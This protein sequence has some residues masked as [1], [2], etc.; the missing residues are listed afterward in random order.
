MVTGPDPP[1][2]G[3]VS[4]PQF[5]S[6]TVSP[7]RKFLKIAHVNAQSLPCHIDEFRS[8]FDSSSFDIILICETW[9]KP[10][11]SNKSVELNDY[12]LF[13]NDR[14]HKGGGGVGVFVKSHLKTNVLHCSD[15]TIPDR[16][17]FIF[18]DVCVNETHVL[19]SVC[20][21]APNLGFMAE[22][23]L[24]LLDL[25]ARYSHVIVMGDFNTDL[26]GPP[27]YDNTFLNNMFQSFNLS[28]LP[29]RA[30]HHTSTSETWLDLMAVSD[31]DLVAH[32]GQVPAPGLSRHDLLFCVYKLRAQKSK[33]KFIQYRNLKDV[34]HDSILS[35]AMRLPW[36]DI[37]L[38]NDVDLMVGQF[39]FL[40]NS[41]LEHVA[42]MITKRVTK[43]PVPWFTD[44]IRLLQK[45]RDIS[46][47][48]AKQSKSPV[49]WSV[50]KRLRNKTQQ[51]IRNAKIRYYYQS[52]NNNC[53]STKLLWAK[54]KELGIGKSV[55]TGQ[56]NFD[57]NSINDF[58]VNI[59]VDSS[60]AQNFADEL[61][62]ARIDR[63]LNQFSFASVSEHDV[64]R[65]IMSMTSNAV[66]ADH[67]PINFLKIT[68]PITLP[69]ITAIFNSS[70]SSGTFPNAWKSA[71]VRPLPKISNPR[72]PSD[73]RPISILPALSKCLER[74]AHQQISRYLDIHNIISSVQ[75]GFRR[76]HSTT[77]ALLTITDDI[78]NAMDNKKL[79]ILTLFD[80]TKAFD[81]V[82]HPLL[83]IKLKSYGMSD[84]CVRWV[85]SY[86][87]GRRQ[88][89]RSGTGEVSDWRPVTR[90]VPQGSV[91]GPLLF[92][93][94][95][96]DIT[97]QIRYSNFHLYAD[98][99]Q[100]YQHFSIAECPISVFRLN[101]DIEAISSWAR[102]LGLKLNELKTQAI[103]ISHPRLLSQINIATLPKLKLNNSELVYA[104]SVKNLGVT[105]N[106]TLTWDHQVTIICNRVFAGIHSLKRHASCLPFNVKV[107]LVKS[108][109]LPHFDYCDTV[110]SDM[111]VKLSDKLQRAQNYCIKFIFN[112]RYQDHVTLYYAQ[113][114]ILRLKQIRDYHIL[115]LLHKVLKTKYP[116]YL[117]ER[118]RFINEVSTRNTRRGAL[119]LSIPVHHTTIYNRS[120]TVSACRLWNG[121]PDNIKI[122][123]IPRF[124]AEV[125][126][127]LQRRA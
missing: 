12:N 74:I 3:E 28:V 45:Q 20:Y 33:V 75:S 36:Q 27:T 126:A 97:T 119:L 91:L 15:T 24:A 125:K 76:Y 113:L 85:Q 65:A 10:H 50:Y 19:L 127:F 6:Q 7:Y 41:L 106:R 98:D 8:I 14:V 92:S 18:L 93:I 69:I 72:S 114:S 123:E 56:I 116:R 117:F 54:V 96:N 1:S 51:E 89:V 107:L 111:T 30:T 35:N 86:L 46:F 120:F 94:Y 42:P 29:L 25:M 73:F 88:C 84:R 102:R 39:N 64:Q 9:L 99:L 31:M 44:H 77:T 80:F 81:C 23:E 26:L 90:G 60:G 103:V 87:S 57:L 79:T 38:L 71:I 5:I 83:L 4:L 78:R 66:G 122:L 21:R 2:P 13:R 104:D 17:E 47:R 63:P 48:K 101:C 121:L 16:P 112:L 49:D 11:I 82:Y 61:L 37:L 110:I 95:I 68:L 62:N 59:P 53:K 22:Y 43:K 52:L 70:L 55:S 100:I 67:L 118:F 58:F 109:V 108:L 105:M 32:Y 34:N 124:G 115:L 40:L